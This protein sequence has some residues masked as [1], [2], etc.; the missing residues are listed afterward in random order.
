MA[1]KLEVSF[2]SPQ[3]GWMSIGFDNGENEFHTTTAHAPHPE[4]LAKIL[5]SLSSLLDAQSEC[6]LFKIAWSRNPEAYD[7][8][9]KRSGETASFQVVE[10]PTIE[11][12]E[13]DG[14]IVF[15]HHG[16]VEDFCQAFAETFNQLYADRETDEFEFNWRQSFPFEEYQKFLEKC[17]TDKRELDD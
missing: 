3:C 8:F 1:H 11:H 5:E 15:S 16:S 4:A 2:N 10:Y 17:P 6:H 14:E 7:L 12:S 13:N 9:F